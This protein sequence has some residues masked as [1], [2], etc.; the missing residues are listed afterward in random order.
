MNRLEK[1]SKENSAMLGEKERFRMKVQ[2]VRE[3]SPLKERLERVAKV[4][5]ERPEVIESIKEMFATPRL[6]PPINPDKPILL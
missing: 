3:M 1:A 4:Y 5:R 2:F 6:T